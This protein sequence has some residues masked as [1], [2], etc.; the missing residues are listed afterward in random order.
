MIAVVTS[1]IGVIV[2]VIIV[3]L[4]RNDRLHVAHGLGWLTAALLIAGLGFAPS[5]FD[6][7]ALWLGVSYPPALAFT[8]GFALHTVKLL[9]DDIERSNLKMQQ[10][11]LIQQIAIL[12]LEL[13]TAKKKPIANQVQ[14]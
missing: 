9:I 13:R 6:K 1:I 10:T 3:L 2:A 11:R 5:V 4:I 12:E 8:I 14:Q 7:L